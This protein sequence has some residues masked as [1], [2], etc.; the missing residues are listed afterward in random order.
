MLM[1]KRKKAML[2]VWLSTLPGLALLSSCAGPE[3]APHQAIQGVDTDDNEVYNAYDSAPTSR[4][5]T[6]K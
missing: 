1:T 3:R 2:V 5:S 6:T 4:A